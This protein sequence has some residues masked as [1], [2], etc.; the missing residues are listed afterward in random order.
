MRIAFVLC[1][2][3]LRCSAVEGCVKAS[4]MSCGMSAKRLLSFGQG[5]VKR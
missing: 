2:Y 1:S 4:S 3:L 5:S